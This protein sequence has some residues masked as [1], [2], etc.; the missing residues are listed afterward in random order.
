MLLLAALGGG[1]A[2]FCIEHAFPAFF[3]HIKT[4][5][6][7]DGIRWLRWTLLGISCLP[8]LT[9]VWALWL[10]RRLRAA[11]Q[12]PLPGSIVLARTR[13]QRGARVL[14][15]ARTLFAIAALSLCIPVLGWYVAG[16][17]TA[18]FAPSARQCSAPDLVKDPVIHE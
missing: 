10:A 6:R 16:S 12:F 1:I 8:V 7:C 3:D 17:D 14:W 18:L 9:A 2:Y 4:L 15:R 11:G 13:I 5:P